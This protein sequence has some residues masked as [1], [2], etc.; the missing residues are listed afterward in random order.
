MSEV[1]FSM[2]DTTHS[3]SLAFRDFIRFMAIMVKGDTQAKLTLCFSLFDSG[4]TGEITRHELVQLI[5]KLP[6]DRIAR[7]GKM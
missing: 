6:I 2:L 4:K 5:S 3:G 7:K 1:A